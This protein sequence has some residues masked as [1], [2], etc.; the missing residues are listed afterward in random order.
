MSGQKCTW[1]EEVDLA[2]LPVDERESVLRMLEPH[3]GMWDGRLGT[4][5]ATTQRIAVTPG[6]KPVHC[7]PYRAGSRARVA[8]KHKIDLII[9]QKVIETATCEWA[10]PIGFSSN[11]TDPSDFV[12]IIGN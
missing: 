11:R 1:K 12:W 6:S 3:R 7:Q 5:S 8:E 4:F 10:S 9:E 2:H